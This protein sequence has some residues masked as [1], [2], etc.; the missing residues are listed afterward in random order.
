MTSTTK[1][2]GYAEPL[3]AGP[4]DSVAFKVSSAGPAFYHAEILR[5]VCGDPDP[6]GPGQRFERVDAAC[7][8]DH[9]GRFQPTDAGSYLRIDRRPPLASGAAF[10]ITARIW[11]TLP[12]AGPQCL[13]SWWDPA[14]ERG[15]LL[16]LD[17]GG[18]LELS[19]GGAAL[20]S[21][22]TEDRL[23][24][25]RWYA[26]FAAFDPETA[27]ARVGFRMLQP[28]AGLAE[29]DEATAAMEAWREPGEAAPLLIGARPRGLEA[30]RLFTRANYNGKIEDPRL[31]GQALDESTVPEGVEPLAHWDFA[32]DIDGARARDLGAHGLHGRTVNLPTRGVTG[33]HWDGSAED[34]RLTPAHYGAIHFH[35]DDLSDCLWQTDFSFEVPDDLRS[36]FYAARLTAEGVESYVPFFVR[37]ARGRPTAPVLVLA[38]TA[39]YLSYA[40]SHIKFDSLNTENLYEAVI[41]L[42][43]DELYLNAHRELGLS[44]YDTHSDGSGVVYSSPRR[45]ILNMRPGL[46][47]FNCLNDTH[48]LA[49]LEQA[50]FAY[51]VAS[52]ED[53]HRDGLAL[54]EPYR[55]VITGSH[56]EYTSTAMWDALAAYQNAGGRHMYLGGNGFYWRIAYSDSFPGVVENRRGVTGVRT[57]EGE[58]GEHHLS[59]TGEAGG[60]W[61]S[62]GRPPQA[63]VGV[64]FSATL[65][66]RSTYYRRTAESFAPE[67]A[68]VFDGVGPRERIG[69]FGCRGG[70]AA[71]LEL[72]RWDRTL[73]AP[74]ASV[75]LA[76]TED[77][78]L[79]GLLSV[80]EYITTTRALDGLQ[81][82][83]VRADMV[84]FATPGGGAVW[85]TGS[86]AWATS[87]CHE[88]YDNNVARITGNVLR[89]A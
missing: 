54:L 63:L 53:L 6:N 1:I 76:T 4:G 79:G 68:F 71:G 13:L 52:D 16:Q 87:L 8:G 75:V 34:W 10:A 57:W 88:G 49:W 2:L 19:L 33:S 61:R 60:L 56:P 37:A 25:R 72:D 51:D 83:K 7:T 43:E 38:A 46:Y 3:C 14:T 78:G 77:V 59:F 12:A 35:H 23:D 67:H 62:L 84:F 42:S 69:D 26:V 31:F 58:P 50:G 27:S 86:I 30:G 70:G 66:D 48:I 20:S 55:V 24:E 39:T 32:Q 21:L 45:P 44:H 5:I 15:I 41:P 29:A 81:N 80:E 74:P 40:N 85:S 9:V 82:G 47:T 18:R 36:G 11:P 17:D 28:V 64:G 22:A 65:F 89:P 73:G